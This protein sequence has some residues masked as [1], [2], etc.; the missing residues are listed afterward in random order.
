MVHIRSSRFWKVY[1]SSHYIKTAA[2]CDIELHMY[3]FPRFKMASLATVVPNLFKNY[4]FKFGCSVRTKCP[5]LIATFF[6]SWS[7]TLQ[8]IS[9]F[10]LKYKFIYLC[11]M[12]AHLLRC[13]L[14]LISVILL[15]L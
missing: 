9:L 15:Y 8:Y 10:L 5:N 13:R 4:L 6:T 14:A 1:R 3:F 11:I 7:S 2:F 12:E